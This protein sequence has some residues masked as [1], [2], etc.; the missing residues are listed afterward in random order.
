MKLL[1]TTACAGQHQSAYLI[2]KSRHSGLSS[3]GGTSEIDTVSAQGQG[4]REVRAFSSSTKRGQ[5]RTLRWRSGGK[6]VE[7]WRTSN[8]QSGGLRGTRW[9][10]Y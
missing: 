5:W 3:T 4:Q 10:H 6:E 1:V 2:Q 8:L 9:T 7:R